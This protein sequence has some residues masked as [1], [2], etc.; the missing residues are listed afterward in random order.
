MES[1][2]P[3]LPVSS[4]VADSLTD[5]QM[6]ALFKMLAWYDDTES[7]NKVF[8]LSGRSGS[9]KSTLIKVFRNISN[10][11]DSEVRYCAY[12][13]KAVNVLNSKGIP[14]V[15]LHRLIYYV[16]KN[17]KTK[18]IKFIKKEPNELWGIKLIILDEYSMVGE[19]I[20]KDLMSYGIKVILVGDLNQLQPIN[21]NP[22]STNIDA[23]LNQVVRQAKDSPILK[24]ATTV[25]NHK[26]L[27]EGVLS[28]KVIVT[29][30]NKLPDELL[31]NPDFQVICGYNSTRSSINQKIR[32]SLG[33]T[34]RYP[35]PG[36]RV[37]CTANDWSILVNENMNLTNGLQGTVVRVK[38]PE[39]LYCECDNPLNPNKKKDY[40]WWTFYAE[41]LFDGC[42]DPL[43]LYI[44]RCCFD[45][46][47]ADL[48]DEALGHWFE[49]GYC[50]TCNKAQGSEFKNVILI[51]E[52]V[53]DR[54]K[55]LYTGIT[56]AKESLIVAV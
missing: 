42:K 13:G 23:Q 43:A 47:Y 44:N 16:V 25:L 5:D 8:T 10:I 19:S 9:G 51:D 54:Y 12:T 41:I 53:G 56:R 4:D 37:I 14:A 27:G 3:K 11:D 21:D 24:L 17:K 33:R 55:W 2:T 39:D 34:G 35:V 29:P 22:I 32:K 26:E 31:C 15:T 49:F 46:E 38:F 1:V 20:F 7:D 45:Y 30:R 36:D 18:E 52:P 6:L 48:I 50:I 28:N 40:R